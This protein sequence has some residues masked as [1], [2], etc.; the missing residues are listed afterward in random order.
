MSARRLV[1]AAALGCL[2]LLGS[3][4]ALVAVP[5]AGVHRG[6]GSSAAFERLVT[7]PVYRNSAGP[8]T[9]TVA[10]I[11]AASVD[12]RT[13]ISTDSAGER[14]T[15]T[16]IS[17]ARRPKP[18]GALAVGGEPTSV[19][20]FGP[21]VLVAVNTSDSFTEPSGRLLVVRLTDRSIAA[22][23]DLGGQP[24][25][26]AISPS[27]ATGGAYAAI[28]IENERDEEVNDGQIPQAPGGFLVAIRLSGVPGLWQPQPIDL[29]PGWLQ[30][31][32]PRLRIPSPNTSR[33]T[34]GTRPP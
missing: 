13:L 12:G 1:L 25:S 5:A 11:T 7:F 24:D 21:Y 10:E 17:D 8:A 19:A 3:G 30:Q 6:H 34:T 27:G 15:F 18:A 2:C 20:V 23:L 26:I 22:D 9:E 31:A 4:S 32:S 14:V 29:S 16:D 33:S 28:A